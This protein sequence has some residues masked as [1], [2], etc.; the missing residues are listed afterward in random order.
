MRRYSVVVVVLASVMCASAT[1]NPSAASASSA[2][3][4]KIAAG[5]SNTCAL[6]GNGTAKCWGDNGLGQLGDNNGTLTASSVPV[7]V[8]NAA[9]TGPLTGIA[10]IVVG[11]AEVCARMR[12]GTA[13]CWGYGASGGLGA[14]ATGTTTQCTTTGVP[15]SSLPVTVENSRGTGP[16]TGVAQLTLGG[17][18]TCA[19]L[20]DHTARCWGSNYVGELGIGN[21]TGPSTCNAGAFIP[22]SRLPVTVKNAVGTGP[23]TNVA[24]IRASNLETCAVLTNTT[25]D[26]WGTY[27]GNLPVAIRDHANT[28]PL[29]GVASLAAGPN[30]SS[31]CARMKNHTVE[32]WGKHHPTTVRNT[33]NTAP[34]ENV[35]AVAGG[36]AHWCALLRNAAVKCWGSNEHGEL[37]D[38][39]RINRARPVAVKGI[40]LPVAI[41]AGGQHSC[42]VSSGGT[43]RCWGRNNEGELG[44]GTT[45]ARSST[46][47][48]VKGL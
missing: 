19:V 26:C 29:T 33:A 4:P 3:F 10:Q 44:N 46:P 48:I 47:V 17:G 20:V 41:A 7:S 40:A 32:C 28:G 24:S 42:A 30:G 13:R 39:T 27:E 18:Q 1:A 16:L 21:K 34:L 2:P 8:E 12:D 23:L 11:L 25:V 6:F 45:T 9:G 14:G 5:G 36:E 38:G 22:C 43:V 37:G 31:T 35:A 15:C